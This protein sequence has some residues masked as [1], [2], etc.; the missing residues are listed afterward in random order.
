MVKVALRLRQRPILRLL[1][2]NLVGRMRVQ[3][4]KKQAYNQEFAQNYGNP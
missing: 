2:S 4:F 3:S 1:N